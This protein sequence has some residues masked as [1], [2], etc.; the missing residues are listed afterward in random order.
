MMS[1]A[2]ILTFLVLLVVVFRFNPA[3]AV[4]AVFLLG[5]IAAYPA[6]A[7]VVLLVAFGYWLAMPQKRRRR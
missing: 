3:L 1:Y 4:G 6:F 7:T 2:L 5:F